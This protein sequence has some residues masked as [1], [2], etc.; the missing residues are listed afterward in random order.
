MRP[1][2]AGLMTPVGMLVTN[3]AFADATLQPMFAR[4]RYHGMVVWSWQQALMAAGIA[5]QRARSDLPAET[6]A[7]LATAHKE[8]W[9]AIDATY[10]ARSS[11]LWSWST[12][13]GQYIL[14]AY[15]QRD[16]DKTEANAVQ[17]WSTIYLAVMKK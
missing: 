4:D 2:P 8:L 1:F 7:M 13:D 3:A 14:E 9:Q 10:A 17:L 15:G 16:G 11:E 6:Q 12:K 5:K